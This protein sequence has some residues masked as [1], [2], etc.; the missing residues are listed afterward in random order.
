MLW[1]EKDIIKSDETLFNK[2]AKYVEID[3]MSSDKIPLSPGVP[4]TFYYLHE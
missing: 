4:L 1:N 2:H 3:V